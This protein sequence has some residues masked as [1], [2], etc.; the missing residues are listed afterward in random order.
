MLIMKKILLLIVLSG[1]I[2]NSMETELPDGIQKVGGSMELG[3]L[4]NTTFQNISAF[5]VKN[6]KHWNFYGSEFYDFGAFGGDLLT[7]IRF[8]L[9]ERVYKKSRFIIVDYGSGDGALLNGLLKKINTL[10]ENEEYQN[11]GDVV[12]EAHS[13]T[14]E[15][16]TE[17]LAKQTCLKDRESEEVK[18][19]GNHYHHMHGAVP[20]EMIEESSVFSEFKGQVDLLVSNYTFVHFHDPLGALRGAMKLLTPGSGILATDGIPVEIMEKSS[21]GS[22]L[23]SFLAPLDIPYIISVK[24]DW[25][26]SVLLQ[27]THPGNT[28]LSIPYSEKL[29]EKQYRHATLKK[30]AVYELAPDPSI[31]KISYDKNYG[32]MFSNDPNFYKE[33]SKI[34]KEHDREF[35]QKKCLSIFGE[36]PLCKELR[37]ASTKEDLMNFVK[38]LEQYKEINDFDPM[39]I[40]DDDGNF[41]LFLSIQKGLFPDLLDSASHISYEN[42]DQWERNVLHALAENGRPEDF[43]SLKNRMIKDLGIIK[44]RALM[45]KMNEE[46]E[47]FTKTPMDIAKEEENSP[48]LKLFNGLERSNIMERRKRS[49]SSIKC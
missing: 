47:Y 6:Q 31:R 24:D 37:E 39:N 14:G 41:L 23:F 46:K 20:L 32:K 10:Q 45:K 1:S 30:V 38:K 43:H 2:G 12:F 21:Y 42:R 5:T 16:L 36:E 3:S 19:I 26:P 9:Q 15:S 7:L 25:G 27:N 28:E 17:N 11:L 34:E 40:E 48:L 13:F 18:R 35:P 33:I 44:A 4:K 22:G 49:G 8:G 29:H